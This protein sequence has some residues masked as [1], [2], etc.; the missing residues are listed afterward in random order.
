M[1]SAKYGF[2]AFKLSLLHFCSFFLAVGFSERIEN[3]IT[4]KE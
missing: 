4:D 1:A 3:M 2:T